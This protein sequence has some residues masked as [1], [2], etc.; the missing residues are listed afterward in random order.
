[1]SSVISINNSSLVYRKTPWDN[2][3]FNIETKEILNI[4]YQSI[5]DIEKLIQ[6][7]ESTFDNNGLMYFRVD[8]NERILKEKLLS[9]GYYICETSINLISKNIQRF[10]FN[11]I[12]KKDY[13]LNS[14]LN[15]D[16]I[17]QLKEICF[18]SFNYSRFHE[19]PFLK[20]EESKERY[21]NWIGDLV[22]QNKKILFYEKNKIVYS[23]MFYEIIEKDTVTLLLGGSKNSFG[24]MTPIFWTSVF[25]FLKNKG[26]KTINVTVSAA[27]ITILN[28][29][30]MNGFLI[31][32]ST[33]DYHKLIYKDKK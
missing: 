3:V 15:I 28:L 31:K 8:S 20:K 13:I 24:Q 32:N 10:D 30:L 18:S 14:N 6:S 27:N 1:M 26:I 9:N 4:D 22:K 7:F 2:K 16:Y 21:R 29:Y 33:L 12:F 25:N 11:K 23:F 17:E 5:D 19:D